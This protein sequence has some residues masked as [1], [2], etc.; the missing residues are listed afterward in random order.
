MEKE[1]FD[2]TWNSFKTHILD[3]YQQQFKESS[4]SDVTLVTED[5]TQ[6]QA[7]RFVLSSCSPILKDLL[8]SNPH[9]HPLIFLYGVKKTELECILQFMYLGET[10]IDY[11]R[12]DEFLDVVRNFKIKQLFQ[13]QFS[14][15]DEFDKSEN[16]DKI[17]EV[18]LEDVMPRQERV[19]YKARSDSNI[20]SIKKETT[21]NFVRETQVSSVKCI[22][23]Q[24]TASELVVKEEE[25]NIETSLNLDETPSTSNEIEQGSVSKAKTI[26]TP[27]M[28]LP[29]DDNIERN[30][31]KG[32]LWS[33]K[34]SAKDDPVKN[35][36]N[37]SE[38]MLYFCDN[39]EY[40]ATSRDKLQKHQQAIHKVV[41]YPCKLCDFQ[42]GWQN[43]LQSHVESKH[44]YMN[45]LTRK[46]I[47]RSIKKYKCGQCEY[48]AH[49]LTILLRHMQQMHEENN[50]KFVCDFHD[51]DY[52]S[53]TPEAITF[54]QRKKHQFE[55]NVF[56]TS[57]SSLKSSTD[58]NKCDD[59]KS[60]FKT[61]EGFLFHSRKFHKNQFYSCDQCDYKSLSKRLFKGHYINH[62]SL[63]IKC[64]QCLFTTS[65]HQNLEKHQEGQHQGRTY[66]CD[67][68]DYW[69]THSS[70]VFKHKQRKHDGIRHQCDQCEYQA[71]TMS[72]L[73]I[74]QRSKHEGIKFSCDQCEYTATFKRTLQSHKKAI[75]EG[76]QF[77][78]DKCKYTAKF[79]WTLQ[80]HKKDKHTHL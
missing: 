59:C 58:A 34:T 8:L 16:R 28:N 25:E 79:K 33:Y 57:D 11:D 15:D 53:K 30:E 60:A 63:N 24:I 31:L 27:S 23:Q 19:I 55:N 56:I 5:N 69:A 36:E 6:F 3:T 66:T 52:Q 21:M 18:E 41:A 78:C 47:R 72:D 46:F 68:C 20:S 44:A 42:S 26:E 75:H 65:S 71:T 73:K 39:C 70:S 45:Q 4:F 2:L 1:K 54:H 37:Q 32:N 38:G 50:V 62:S 40:E 13:E 9:P 49:K 35:K 10:K 7:H 76:I 77:F 17:S 61:K 48:N 80:K 14:S 22:E 64:D 67:K 51:C 29:N 43:I 12:I 74:H